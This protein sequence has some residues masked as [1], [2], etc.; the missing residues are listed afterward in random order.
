M[1]CI[2]VDQREDAMYPVSHSGAAAVVD[3]SCLLSFP[4]TGP[5]V[6]VKVR[7]K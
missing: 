1:I 5:P 2:D 7:R 6:D 4:G 3:F